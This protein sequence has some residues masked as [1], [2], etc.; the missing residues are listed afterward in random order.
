MST[1]ELVE[2]VPVLR[3]HQPRLILAETARDLGIARWQEFS[4]DEF[5]LVKQHNIAW[6]SALIAM[7][8]AKIYAANFNNS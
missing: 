7:Q 1:G 6:I 4:G 5:S 8:K 2:Q 3:N